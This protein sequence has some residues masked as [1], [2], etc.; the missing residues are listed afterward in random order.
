[1]G[2]LMIEKPDHQAADQIGW[3]RG[4]LTWQARSF[5]AL[6]TLTFTDPWQDGETTPYQMRS[7]GR[8]GV[9]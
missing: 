7:T 3:V 1:M 4:G 6:R 9:W 8:G 2:Y 5:P